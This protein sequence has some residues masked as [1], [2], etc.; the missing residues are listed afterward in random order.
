MAKNKMHCPRC[1]DEMNHHAMKIDSSEPPSAWDDD[2]FD[3]LLQEVHT[4]PNCHLTE[5][6]AASET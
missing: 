1:G 2:A 4:C 3:G 6:R 5:F